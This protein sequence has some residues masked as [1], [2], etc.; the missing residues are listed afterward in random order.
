MVRKGGWCIANLPHLGFAIGVDL[1]PG[2]LGKM[3]EGVNRMAGSKVDLMHDVWF[4]LAEA[5]LHHSTPD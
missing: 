1:E 4:P 3:L 5:R 2:P